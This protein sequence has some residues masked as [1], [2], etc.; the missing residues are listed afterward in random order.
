MEGKPRD[1]RRFK[2]RM[3]PNNSN[4]KFNPNQQIT[5]FDDAESQGSQVFFQSNAREPQDNR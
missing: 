1:G 2:E 5:E 4:D 3:E